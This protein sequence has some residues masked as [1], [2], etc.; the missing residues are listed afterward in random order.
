MS[1]SEGWLNEDYLILFAEE[2]VATMSTAYGIAGLL[3]NYQIIGLHGS[4]NFIFENSNGLNF[5]APTVPLT[6]KSIQPFELNRRDPLKIDHRFTGRIKWYVKP[7]AF[8]GSPDAPENLTWIDSAKHQQL[9]HWW[10]EK[11]REQIDQ[12]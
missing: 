3:P 2:D 1:F 6:A 10:N 5:L 11:Y 9:V 4:D 12:S 7:L 8:G